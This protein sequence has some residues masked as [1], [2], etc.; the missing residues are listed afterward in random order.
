METFSTGIHERAQRFGD[1]R[2]T[3]LVV[4]HHGALLAL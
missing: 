2:V 4:G 1:Q 3:H